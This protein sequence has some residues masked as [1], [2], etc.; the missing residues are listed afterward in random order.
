MTF[1]QIF[2]ALY[3]KSSCA[4]ERRA[5]SSYLNDMPNPQWLGWIAYRNERIAAEKRGLGVRQ[6]A[7]LPG[8]AR[9]AS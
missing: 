1:A 3:L 9:R 8:P 7:A 5:A 4:I 2:D 6:P